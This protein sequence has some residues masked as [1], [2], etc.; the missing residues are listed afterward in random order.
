MM[1][2]LQGAMGVL[3]ATVWLFGG[4]AQAGPIIQDQIGGLSTISH[5]MPLGQT[6]T[7]EDPHVTFGFHIE[8]A[9][10]HIGTP[11]V[12]GVELYEGAGVGGA[13]LAV[14]PLASFPDYYSGWHDVDFSAVTLTVGQV[15]TATITC[16]TERAGLSS[17]QPGN[18]QPG[19]YPG[20][21]IMLLGVLYDWADATFRVLPVVPAPGAVVLGTLGAGL[22]GWLRR[23][24]TL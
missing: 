17:F 5:F 19:P 10:P 11:Y 24:R 23:R 8:D 7:A 20:G 4:H 15:Y 13:L 22:V 1:T 18:S 16:P 14:A 12:V 6:F 21:E 9:N 3:A 2:R